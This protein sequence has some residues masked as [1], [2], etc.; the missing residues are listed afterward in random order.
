VTNHRPA[1]SSLGTPNPIRD[2]ARAAEQIIE[3][4]RDQ[5]A[6][7][8]LAQGSRL[9]SERV[10]ADHFSVSPPTVREAIRALSSMGMVESRHGSG[11]YVTAQPTDIVT[12]SLVTAAQLQGTTVA[13]IIEMLAGLNMEAAK[14]AVVNADATDIER[15]AA[16][17]DA[18]VNG[19][20]RDEI[21]GGVETF[22]RALA[23]SAHHPL[24]SVISDFLIRVLVAVELE[25]F[26]DSVQLWRELTEP[27]AEVR[28]EIVDALRERDL[29]RL[30]AAVRAYHSGAIDDLDRL[31]NR[32]TNHEMTL[33]DQRL[34][35]VMAKLTARA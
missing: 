35:G 26:P 18:I 34:A 11:T 14:R 1:A 23:E 24:Q 12:P 15:L 2:R 8:A 25:V 31:L 32:Q 7:G 13:E 4:L 9:P 29:T 28:A 17:Q 10:I 33:S 22:L 20:S 16:G 21:L 30:Q 27:L 6:R 19:R 5:I 3:N